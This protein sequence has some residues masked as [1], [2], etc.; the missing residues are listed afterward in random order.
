MEPFD[1]DLVHFVGDRVIP[2]SSQAVN[3]GPDQEMSSDL[4]CCAEKLVNVT[5]AITRQAEVLKISRGSVYY[6]PRPVSSADLAIM[7]HLDQLHLELPFAGSRMLRGLLAAEGC[8]IGRRHVKTLMRRTGIEALYRRPRTTKPEPGH[9]IYPYLLRGLAIERANQ[10]WAMD[11]TYIPMA[12]GFVYLAVVLDWAT[13]RVLSWRLSI[14][15]EAAF[16][17]ETLE[18]AMVRHGKPEISAQC[19][20]HCRDNTDQGSQFTGAAFTGV[21]ASH[22]I[23]ISMDGKG[24]WR[25]NVFV[26]RLWRSVEYEEVYLRAYETVG[27]ARHSIGRYL[28]FYNRASEHPSVYVV[29]EKRLC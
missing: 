11:I 21:L 8:K 3:A 6:L 26:E 9:K 27:E 23:A 17:V 24:A 19:R 18:D 12:R 1:G 13:R 22:D 16:C 28:D 25:D 10:V 4:L 29:E 5:L 14:T 15:M 20:R 2:V 7:R